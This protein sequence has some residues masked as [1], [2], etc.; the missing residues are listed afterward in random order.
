M[1]KVLMFLA[2]MASLIEGL[3]M[4]GEA[5]YQVEPYAAT[6]ATTAT[7]ATAPATRLGGVAISAAAG[8]ESVTIVTD[9]AGYRVTVYPF[10]GWTVT[11]VRANGAEVELS[12]HGDHAVAIVPAVTAPV[13]GGTWRTEVSVSARPTTV[14]AEAAWEATT[15]GWLPSMGRFDPEAPV[16]RLAVAEAVAKMA[17]VRGAHIPA[18]TGIFADTDSRA[19]AWLAERGILNGVGEGLFEPDSCITQEQ[20]VCVMARSLRYAASVGFRPEYGRMRS[21]PELEGVSAFATEDV[22]WAGHR[23]CP[24][25]VDGFDPQESVTMKDF[26]RVLTWANAALPMSR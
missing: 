19:V 24:T 4:V 6:T 13:V 11:S 16:S 25:P 20:L 14:W 10:E 8:V 9:D 7:N 17:E 5:A 15:S 12:E 26:V 23:N 1:K 22:L 21:L 18:G 2:V 3:L